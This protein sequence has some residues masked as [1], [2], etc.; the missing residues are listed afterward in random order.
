MVSTFSESPA[1][2]SSPTNPLRP[3]RLDPL[4][5]T[6]QAHPITTSLPT[7]DKL[8]VQQP[9]HVDSEAI[10]RAW[11]DVFEQNIAAR[12]VQGVLSTMTD[13]GWWRDLF[14][15]TWD[16]RTFQG[17]AKIGK[18]LEDKL[19]DS[20]LSNVSFKSAQ[21]VQPF[22]DMSWVVAQFEFETKIAKG[23]GLARL[24][25]TEVGWKAVIICTNLEDLKDFP[26]QIG[27]LRNHLP[28]HGKW[29][30]Q[31]NVEREFSENDP[32]VLI[33]GGG[34][35]GLNIAARLKHLGVTNLVVERHSRI[36]NQWRDRYEALCLHDPVCKRH[37]VSLFASV[38]IKLVQG[39]TTCLT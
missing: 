38:L 13:D 35:G 26:E 25:P 14:A 39:L 36:G 23:R 3:Y 19:E 9:K 15:M 32:A 27:S 28:N 2:Q 24:V 18:F 7:F 21:Y 30:E 33:I 37:T 6:M 12:D 11:I 17:P 8:G 22:D 5:H 29:A 20:G 16:L 10:S 4:P 31:R 1:Y 34:Q